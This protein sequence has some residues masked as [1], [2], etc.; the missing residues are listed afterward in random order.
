MESK[1]KGDMARK[2]ELEKEIAPLT[3]EIRDK[4]KEIEEKQ[5]KLDSLEDEVFADFARLVAAIRLRHLK[6]S[7]L[8]HLKTLR[9]YMC[10]R[11]CIII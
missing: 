3:K 11:R 1:K 5:I 6:T 10:I 2:A 7:R 8:R 4:A 9:L